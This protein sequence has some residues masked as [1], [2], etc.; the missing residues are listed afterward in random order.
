MRLTTLFLLFSLWAQAQTYEILGTVTDTDRQPIIGATAE[1]QHPWGESVK[2]VDTDLQGRF[3]LTGIPKGGYRLQINYLGFATR[4][5]ELTVE[6][7]NL[8]LD[9][10]ILE[11]AALE[12][13]AV[14]VIEKAPIA[15][16]MDDTIQYNAAAFKTMKDASAEE[17]LLKMPGM[18][19]SGGQVQ[20]QGENIT[21]VLVDGKPFFGDDP[22]AALKNLPAEVIDKIQ[23]YDQASEQSQFSGVQDGNT[24]KTINIVTKPGMSSGQFGK[25]YAGYGTDS[26]YQTGGNINLFDGARRISLIGMANNVNQQ[27]FSSDDILGVLGQS[28]G[29]RRGGP[30]GR[31]GFRGNR[32]ANDFL[33]SSRGGITQ[34][35]AF[36]LNYADQ[37]GK[38]AEV[39][40]SYFF[41]RGDNRTDSD[42]FRQLLSQEGVGEILLSA[43]NIEATNINHRFN[44]RLEVQLDSFNSLLF[45]PRVTMQLNDGTESSFSS[46]S[47]LIQELNNASSD[48]ASQLTGYSLEGSLLWRR[49]TRKDRRTLSVNLT[50]SYA[51]RR[52]ESALFSGNQFLVPVLR[53]D[54]LDQRSTLDQNNWGISTRIEYTEPIG[55]QSQLVLT[56]NA[57]LRQDESDRITNDLDPI[58]GSYTLLNEPLSNIFAN[59]FWT[60]TGGLGYSFNKGRD[61]R[62]TFRANYQYATLAGNQ[63]LPENRRFDQ[64]FHN[65]LPFAF[66]SWS[67]TRNRN[68]FM[69]YRS[70]TQ[71]PEIEQLQNVVN[72][73]NPLQLSVGNPNLRQSESH[74]VFIRYRHTDAASSRMFFAFVGGG[75]TRDQIVNSLWFAGSQNP[76]FEELNIQ[77]GA[78]L[79]QPINASGA[80]NARSFVT[81]GIPLGWLKSNLNFDAA[82]NFQNNPGLINGLQTEA[83]NHVLSG[84]LTLSS[85]IS[86]MLDFS[87]SGR[88]SWNVVTRTG[89]Q[90]ED[91]AFLGHQTTLRF[92]W[93]IWEGFVFR[94]EMSHQYFGGLAEGFNQ[95][96][97]LWNMAIGKKLFRN[98]RGEIALSVFDLLKQN[99]NISRNVTEAWI[100]DSR[101]NALQQYV[102]LI[103]TYNLRHFGKAPERGNRGDQGPGWMQ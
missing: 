61:L 75:F 19:L 15:S 86:E 37:W 53:T 88:P 38:D 20:A 54:T 17:L 51:P 76:L 59:D 64:G 66:L 12:L 47:L 80:W 23:V 24:A 55:P 94:T 58:L 3:A 103:F 28:G 52:G 16:Q 2:G 5:F 56:Y 99:R 72:N 13:Q 73:Q 74:N 32:T 101:T 7:Q 45:T 100:E 10:I 21:R 48:F 102:M 85:N 93:Q 46:T 29:G 11:E 42:Q 60:H 69:I 44:M 40:A 78:Q 97:L 95:N 8:L 96:F 90:G 22:S 57:S 68:F 84:G 81:Y 4:T 18:Q 41:N 70:S 63:R 26:R 98:E 89:E 79:T 6:N 14:E 50:P 34:T 43:N 77:R 27:N 39:T 82:Y 91:D 1:L 62:F 65:I 30:G 36:G 92:N 83:R 49:K 9:A 87:L 35:A 67:P 25:I 33:V 31:G 71:L